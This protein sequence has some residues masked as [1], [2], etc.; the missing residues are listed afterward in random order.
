MPKGRFFL[1]KKKLFPDNLINTKLHMAALLIYLL[2]K[3]SVL[4]FLSWLQEAHFP[5]VIKLSVSVRR[6]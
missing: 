1:E 3:I 4:F 2:P 6:P 5:L